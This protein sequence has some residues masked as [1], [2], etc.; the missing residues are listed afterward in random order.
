MTTLWRYKIG[1][2]WLAPV[3]TW[4]SAQGDLKKG[5]FLLTLRIGGVGG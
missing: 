1:R 5:I 3:Y 4:P 2:G